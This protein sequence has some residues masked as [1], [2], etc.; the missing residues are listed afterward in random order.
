ME[1][2][3]NLEALSVKRK[4]EDKLNHIYRMIKLIEEKGMKARICGE[5]FDE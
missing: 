2:G 3:D 1:D 4:K 5:K